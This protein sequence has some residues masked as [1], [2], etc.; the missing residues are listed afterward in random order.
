[1]TLCK[2]IRVIRELSRQFLC[3]LRLITM[4]FFVSTIGCGE[5]EFDSLPKEAKSNPTATISLW[6]KNGL[7]PVYLPD[8]E[9]IVFM[10]VGEDGYSDIWER[11]VDGDKERCL[12]CD[13]DISADR[14]VGNPRPTPDGASIVFTA[15]KA[16]YPHRNEKNKDYDCNFL[17]QP[18]VGLMNEIYIADPSFESYTLLHELPID[19]DASTCHSQQSLYA[20]HLS[21]DGEKIGWSETVVSIHE[22]GAFGE[23]RINIGDLN[24]QS[25]TNV[26]QHDPGKESGWRE[27]GGFLPGTDNDVI[28]GSGN[29]KKDQAPRFGDAFRYRLS[30][31]V[32]TNLS[33]LPL[34][35][36]DET[37]RANEDGSLIAWHSSRDLPVTQGCLIFGLNC[38]NSVATEYWLQKPMGAD[39]KRLTYF[40]SSG[41]P[42]FI[43]TRAVSTNVAW[44]P[45][46][47]DRGLISVLLVTHEHRI[48]R[49][50]LK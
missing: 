43:G 30:T 1:M 14:H 10:R 25:I 32:T 40:N 35:T 7:D 27:F 8:G 39:K 41:Y 16:D 31:G 13:L 24:T 26:V 4:L 37:A 15:E 38:S 11:E 49:F 2:H 33:L 48:Y 46:Y 6:F 28:L 20:V 29:I 12:S 5:K 44:E 45:G 23:Y 42:E 17:A 19:P 3:Y 22:N 9:H 47:T 18:G 34:A 50:I 21:P 36:W